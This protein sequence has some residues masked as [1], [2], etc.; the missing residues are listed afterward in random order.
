MKKESWL[1]TFFKVVVWLALLFFVLMQWWSSQAIEEDLKSVKTSLLQ[2]NET[3]KRQPRIAPQSTSREVTLTKRGDDKLPN[4]LTEDPY[5]ETVLPEELGPDFQ[6]LGTRRDSTLGK[7]DNLHPFSNWSEVRSWISMCSTSAARGKFGIYE[8]FAPNNALKMEVKGNPP[9]YWVYLRDDVYWQPLNP[10]WFPSGFEL[11]P[12]FLE[13][14]P[15]TAHDYKFF[16]DSFNN[17]NLSEVG[18]ITSRGLYEDVEYIKVIDDYTFVVKWKTDKY[19]SKSLTGGL[20]PLAEHVYKYFQDGTKIVEDDQDP[21]TYKKNSIWA[22][23]FTQHWAKN[24]IVSCGAWVFDGMSDRMIRFKRNPDH[25]TPYDA[26]SQVNEIEIKS[27]TDTIWQDFKEARTDTYTLRPEKLVEFENFLASPQYQKQVEEKK[28]IDRLDYIANSYVYIGWN[29]A[30]DLFSSTKVRQALTMA[31]DRQRIIRQTLNGKGVEISSPFHINSP[32]TDPSIKPWPYDPQKSKRI[33]EE[34][35][36][37]DASGD[38]IISK[39][40]NGVMVPFTFSLT[41]FVK[42]PTTKA[43]AEY[44]STALKP[45]GIKVEL[46]GVDV[47]D[48]SKVFEDKDFDSLILG[49]SLGAPPEDPRQLWYSTLAG[50]KGSSNAVGFK[51]KEADEIID[52]LDTESDPEKRKALY[53]RFN[54]IIHEQQPYTFLYTPKETLLYREWLKNVFIPKDRQDLVPGANI[55]QPDTNVSWINQQEPRY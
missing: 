37:Y 33:L 16:Y 49:W 1:F 11:A 38:G 30:R 3:L 28:S 48:L 43:V 6:F 54:E 46:N 39:N 7:P 13:K 55:A 31:I 5:F 22:L 2:I 20:S 24:I 51:N 25:F 15:V 52:A 41:Y 50:Q 26:L 34:E 40:I 47:A 45:L 10:N 42:N 35:G 36:W 17:P 14:H 21:D 44:V 32:S 29:S 27:S 23:N 8:T 19:I 9:E 18:A 53:Y 12:Q 4:L